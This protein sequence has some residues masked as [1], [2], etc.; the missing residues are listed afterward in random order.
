MPETTSRYFNRR[1]IQ[2][3]KLARKAASPVIAEI[4]RTLAREYQDLALEQGIGPEDGGST[5]S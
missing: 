1:S 2:H 5:G 4:H 3:M